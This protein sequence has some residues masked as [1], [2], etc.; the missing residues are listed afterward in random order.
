MERYVIAA[1]GHR[2][3]KLFG[4]NLYHPGYIDLGWKMKDFLYKKYSTC[5]PITCISGM[6]LGVDQ[7]FALVALKMRDYNGLDVK[8]VAALPCL[9]QNKNWRDDTYWQN[10][11]SRADEKV[12][13]HNGEYTLWC[14]QK[15]NEY[16]VDNADSILAVWNG[17]SGGTANCIR[18][19]NRKNKE[20]VNIL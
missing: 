10:I 15:R 3:D 20:V 8:V 4:Y 14:M 13:V 5:G 16:M 18:Y 1:T 19:A 7:L 9:N 12:Y 6:A 2:P 11:M 17:T